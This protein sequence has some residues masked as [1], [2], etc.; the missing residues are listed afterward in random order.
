MHNK[1]SVL[2]TVSIYHAFNDG[3]VAVIPL[4]FPI[5]KTLLNLT[6]TQVGIIMGG[7]LLITLITQLVIGGQADI[8]NRSTLLST[9]ILLLSGSLLLLTHIQGFFTLLIFIILL[10]FSA[11]F[12][13]PVG[14]GWISQ[15]F[16]R[17]RLDWAMGIQSAFGDFGAFIAISTTLFIVEI[18]DWSFPFYLWSIAGILC[19]FIGIHLSRNSHSNH[20]TIVNN[21]S[22]RN[23]FKTSVIKETTNIKKI[24]LFLPGIIISGSAWGIIIT[25]LP[26]FLHEKTALSLSIIGIIVSIWIGIGT[27]T[28]AFYGKIQLLIGRKNV[29]IL[30]YLIIGL[31]CFSLSIFTNT[32]ILI[33]IMIFLGISTFL[34]YPALFSFI[35]ETTDERYE[36]KTFGY[37]F[38][39]QL[40]GGT[41]LLFLG[42]ISADIWGI[43]TPFILLGLL[44]LFVAIIFFINR[45]KLTTLG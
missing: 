15:T 7:G 36:G 33:V 34:T 27:I 4:L 12:F 29:V 18:I 28:C 20:I 42:G 44:S 35:S 1:T 30:S 3:S 31:M 11:G 14:V 10:R 13:H 24:K 39:F 6:Y 17:D 41:I 8:K 23:S 9:G 32:L 25:Y 43:W 21:C 26:L 2:S 19:L 40:G 22:T 5:F 16:K 37:I 38:T 45:H